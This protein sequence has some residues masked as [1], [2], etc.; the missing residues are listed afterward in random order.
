MRNRIAILFLCMVLICPFLFV[1]C[2][3]SDDFIPIAEI[4]WE[5]DEVELMPGELFKLNYKVYPN[6]ATEQA[7]T[8]VDVKGNTV[9]DALKMD[10]LISYAVKDKGTIQIV[11]FGRETEFVLTI[12][13]KAGN[14]TKEANCLI[15]KR[16]NPDSIMFEEEDYYLG[17]GQTKKLIVLDN[18]GK[19]LDLSRYE[20]EFSSP[21]SNPGFQV[22][23]QGKGIIEAITKGEYT[24]DLKIKFVNINFAAGYYERTA[25]C[26]LH[27]A[28]SY[29]IMRVYGTGLLSLS[30]DGNTRVVYVQGPGSIHLQFAS[31]NYI[32]ELVDC[33]F[34]IIGIGDNTAGIIGTCG[35]NANNEYVINIASVPATDT[36]FIVSSSIMNQ[37][38]VVYSELLKITNNV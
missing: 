29:D 36:Y 23:D 17:T 9:T 14:E 24:L 31:N 32:I 30:K 10:R 4:V 35:V 25:S 22:Y 12:Q 19:E 38:G 34:D 6:N 33:K 16:N 27:I 37:H 28:D 20:V 8:L 1:G 15:K 5:Y 21:T 13:Y 2:G 18:F 7:P 26:T 11:D 3:E